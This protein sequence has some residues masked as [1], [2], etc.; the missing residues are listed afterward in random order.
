VYSEV[1]ERIEQQTGRIAD[2]VEVIR[3]QNRLERLDREWMMRRDELLTQD[4]D[5][6][7][8]KPSATG[9]VVGMV[10]GGGFGLFWTI[11]A[12][13]MDGS[14]FFPLFGVLII[15][16][17]VWAGLRGITNASKYRQFESQYES[18]R[19]RLLREI[20]RSTSR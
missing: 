8:H 20:E 18:E 13:S 14:S 3:L 1:L 19:Q 16:V 2:D 6:Q 11:T 9:S 17:V 12:M 4:K 5:G 10:V 15:V 7:R